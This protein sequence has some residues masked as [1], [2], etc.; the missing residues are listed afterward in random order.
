[1]NIPLI[2]NELAIRAIAYHH[3]VSGYV[4]NIAATQLENNGP[5]GATY[6]AGDAVAE[7]GGAS[8]YQNQDDVGNTTYKGGRVAVL[9]KPTDD[10]SATLTHIMQDAEQ[11]GIPYVQLN[12]GGY[13]Q[14][15]LTLGDAVPGEVDGLQDE[16][17]ITN[18]TLDY[19]LGWGSIIS[20][21]SWL[22]ND[23]QQNQEISMFFGGAPSSQLYPFSVESFFQELRLVSSLEGPLQYIVGAYYEDHEN[24]FDLFTYALGGEDVAGDIFGVAPP[25]GVDNP[26]IN[27]E[28]I[29][30]SIEQ[31]AFYGELSYKIT[32]Q[33]EF[34]VGARRFDYDRTYAQ[35]SEG[36]FGTFSDN[37]RLSESGTNLKAN[38]SYQ[39]NDDMLLYAQWTEGFRLGDVRLPQFRKRPAMLMIMVSWMARILHCLK[40]LIQ[41]QWKILN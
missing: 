18:L 19:D 30:R 7:F 38:I 12:T 25:F 34:T 36:V 13:T 11:E 9:W 3:D 24:D 28:G 6:N 32:E 40:A 4:K 2:E 16:I 10:F 23:S 31:M 17:S 8:L 37:R 15:N 35:E 5:A 21:S 39:Y 29:D 33:V 26:L 22:E 20:S 1:M 41:I 27:L 14:V